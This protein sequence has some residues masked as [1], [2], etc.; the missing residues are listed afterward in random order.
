VEDEGSEGAKVPY[1]KAR[2]DSE[3]QVGNTGVRKSGKQANGQ[4]R[5]DTLKTY[6]TDQGL[7]GD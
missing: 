7:G 5:A 3:S 2:L 6:R 1:P 4:D